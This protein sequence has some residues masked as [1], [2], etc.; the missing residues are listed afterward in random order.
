LISINCRNTDKHGGSCIFVS[1]E[2]KTR[3]L[4]FLRNLG[5]KKVFEI[6]AIELVD[7]KIT[8]VCIYR[9]PNSNEEIFLALLDEAVNKLL[10]RGLFWCYVAVQPHNQ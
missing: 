6:S 8:V 9:S 7:F 2:L 3:D 4:T 5:R 10:K 1:N